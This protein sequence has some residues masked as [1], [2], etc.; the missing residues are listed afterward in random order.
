LLR[1]SS[2]VVP[3]LDSQAKRLGMRGRISLPSNPEGQAKS[4]SFVLYTY[5]RVM[6]VLLFFNF[7]TKEFYRYC[8]NVD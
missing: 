5:L 1:I 8:N 4:N 2:G 3:T 6:Y 7:M